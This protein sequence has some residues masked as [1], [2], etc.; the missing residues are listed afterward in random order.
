MVFDKETQFVELNC[1]DYDVGMAPDFLGKLTIN[2]DTLPNFEVVNINQD[3]NDVETG[4]IQLACE[5]L[6]LKKKNDVESSKGNDVLFHFSPTA[7][8][9]DLLEQEDDLMDGKSAEENDAPGD[10]GEHTDGEGGGGAS[11]AGVAT[12]VMAAKRLQRAAFGEEGDEEN[13]QAS[14]NGA[15]PAPSRGKLA[16]LPTQRSSRAIEKGVLTVS[17]IK[18]RNFQFHSMLSSNVRP[19][20][21]FSVGTS[22]Y[23]TVVQN[24]QHDPSYEESFN[25]VVQDPTTSVMIVKVEKL[26]Y[27]LCSYNILYIYKLYII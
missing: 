10:L 14:P 18:G 23:E 26:Y 17:R 15:S 6:P 2:F 22:K 24:G 12:A 5:Y 3:L 7:L 8:T 25:F 20:V 11:V 16:R 21:I 13:A 1:Y 27:T 19:Y 4:T 9:D